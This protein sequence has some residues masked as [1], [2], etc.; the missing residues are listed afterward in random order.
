MLKKYGSRKR[1]KKEWKCKYE[2]VQ[3]PEYTLLYPWGPYSL[4]STA[5]IYGEQI[6]KNKKKKYL[7]FVHCC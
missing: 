5:S 7:K 2:K 4:S 6:K 3:L 1:E